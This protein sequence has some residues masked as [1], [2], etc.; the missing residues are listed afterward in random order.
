[1]K[2]NT[3]SPR[4]GY[5]N[6]VLVDIDD[7]VSDRIT[8]NLDL[9]LGS[10]TIKPENEQPAG[11][12]AK[13]TYLFEPD[14]NGYLIIH[15]LHGIYSEKHPG[16]IAAFYK[17]RLSDGETVEFNKFTQQEQTFAINGKEKRIKTSKLHQYLPLLNK[18]IIE[19]CILLN[20]VFSKIIH[21]Q[22]QGEIIVDSKNKLFLKGV[23]ITTP[24]ILH[25][26]TFKTNNLRAAQLSYKGIASGSVYIINKTTKSYSVPRNSVLLLKAHNNYLLREY[27]KAKAIILDTDEI[28]VQK[29][30]AKDVFK[31]IVSIKKGDHTFRNNDFVFVD[32]NTGKITKLNK[33]ISSVS[34]TILSNNNDSQKM[35][36]IVSVENLT[37]SHKN[38]VH[39]VTLLNT[40]KVIKTLQKL[41][42]TS[43]HNISKRLAQH[44]VETLSVPS[45]KT[46]FYSLAS[47]GLSLELI[48]NEMNAIKLLLDEY[49]FKKIIIVIPSVQSSADL[50]EVKRLLHKA[51]LTRSPRLQ[52]YLKITIPTHV[53]L[54]ESFLDEQIDGLLFDWEEITKYMYG[55]EK[56]VD[57]KKFDE[58]LSSD[59]IFQ[60]LDTCLTLSRRRN[61]S[62]YAL[63]PEKTPQTTIN[64][65]MEKGLNGL[66]FSGQ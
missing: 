18:E 39:G 4:K 58:L 13:I 22:Y 37:N 7:I 3:A 43:E 17:I 26:E 55:F 1:M 54:I 11:R 29:L 61:I 6:N 66:L 44:I 15:A 56:S 45:E 20:K 49:K 35:K 21:S 36:N 28:T 34:K 60:I 40:D 31:P 33:S 24:E 38:L 10:L 32:S 19:K 30:L 62:L 65:I 46:F 48:Q 23:S 47:H 9:N 59:L 42:D 2:Q 14:G 53:V 25:D 64:K 8:L 57:N 16:D 27:K 50:L 51:H 12:P 41:E 5:L 63:L 52:L